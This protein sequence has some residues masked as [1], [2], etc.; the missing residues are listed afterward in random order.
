MSRIIMTIPAA[1]ACVL[2]LATGA[3]AQQVEF[4]STVNPVGSGARATGMG[5]AFIAVADDAT[6]ASWNPAGLIQLEKP[7]FSIVYA[8]SGQKQSYHSTLHTEIN[9]SNRVDA[10]GINYA[11]IAQPFVLFKRNMIVSLNYQR[12]YEMNKQ[13]AFAYQWDL[14]DG[15]F[16][17]DNINFWQ[18]GYLYAVSPAFAVQVLPG[19]SLGV[20]INFWSS[21]FGQNGWD[22]FYQASGSGMVGGLALQHAVTSRTT[23]R[24]EG[25]NAHVGALY[26]VT[27]AFSLG[28]VYKTGFDGRIKQ[29]SYFY[30]EQ[31]LGTTSSISRPIEGASRFTMKM[32]PSYGMGLQYRVSDRLT[33]ALD[34]YRTEWS[35]FLIED[36]FGNKTNP[37][38][39]QPLDK[40][41]LKDTVQVRFGTEYLFIGNDRTIAVRAGVFSDPEPSKINVNRFW[42]MAFGTGYSAKRYGLDL[43]YQY[44]RGDNVDGDV[45][46]IQ[47]KITNV[48][49]QSIMLSWIYYF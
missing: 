4:S 10:S 27:D 5:G 23:N 41:T 31:T 17:K 18:R 40:G 22:T 14:G 21:I 11:S 16:L 39:G 12:M 26:N 6:A 20:T 46:A 43:S 29:G 28:L 34:G 7:E 49:Q 19:L 2:L 38:D 35:K 33:F 47:P 25:R 37:L 9:G 24:F 44:R 36:Q 30:Q 42:G 15:D 3:S 8:S 13:A 48:I 1:L 45:A 32:P